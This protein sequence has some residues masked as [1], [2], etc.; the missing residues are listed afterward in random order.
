MSLR[1]TRLAFALLALLPSA[2]FAEPPD[3]NAFYRLS[4]KWRGADMPLDVFNGGGKDGMTH[5]APKTNATGQLWRFAPAG[6]GFYR[7]TTKFKGNDTCLDVINGGPRDNQPEFRP[8]GDFSGQLWRLAGDGR[9]TR[10]KTKF[11]GGGM[12]L[13]IING[14]GDDGQPQLRDCGDFSGQLWKLT[15]ASDA[16]VSSVAN[17]NTFK[18]PRHRDARLD[19]CWSWSVK[20][21]GKRVADWWCKK[22]RWMGAADFK[23]AKADGHTEF[24][25]SKE[26]C[27]DPGCTGFEYITCRDHLPMGQVY[28][29]PVGSLGDGGRRLDVCLQFGKNCG[30]PAAQAFCEKRSYRRWVYFEADEPG[31]GG[32]KTITLGS[33]EKCDGP[34]CTAFNVITCAD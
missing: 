6:G 25:G 4:T 15:R 33:R 8:C 31:G 1:R 23:P 16:P 34:H 9:W 20:D 12:C 26:S 29:N 28:A 24:I 19:V 22:H 30:E 5:L 18:H 27:N 21:C 13:D 32:G 10:L 2:A 7:L 3:P 11:K 14:G 17:T